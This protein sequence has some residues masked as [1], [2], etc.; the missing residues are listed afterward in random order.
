MPIATITPRAAKS[1]ING[2]QWVYDS[3]VER[4]DGPC[5]DG[6]LVSV[7]QSL[8]DAGRQR[9]LGQGFFNGHSKLRVRL[10]TRGPHETIDESFFRRRAREAC[11]YRRD[12]MPGAD[13]RR[14]VFGE[15]DGLPG[16]TVDQFHDVL[17]VQSLCL[18]MDRYKTAVLDELSRLLAADGI[19]V[20]GV[21]E[22][23]DV[24]I[25][26]LEGMEPFAGF[27]GEPFGT[28]VLIE[29]NGLRFQV[30]VANGQKTGYF[31]DQKLNR[32]AIRPLCRGKEVLDCFTHTGSFACNAAVTAKAVTALDISAGA[33]ELAAANARL[34]G[35]E[36]K[37]AFVQGDAFDLLPQWVREGRKF[38][39]VILDPPAL[40][41][42]RGTASRAERGYRELNI[43]GMKL[44]R[45]GGYLA[46]CSCSRFMTEENFAAVALQAAQTCGRT[47]R[48]VEKRAQA[49]DH[50]VLWGADET[51]Y[52]K[53]FVFQVMGRW[54]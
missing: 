44:L 39:V 23:S 19:A 40:T 26:E 11:Q 17:V 10:L 8:K 54:K 48:L 46:T 3:E 41:K 24:K 47:L 53:F 9:V 4:I 29:E 33:L 21:Y 27:L 51:Y 43:R 36:N 34:N 31:L 28:D 37:I 22:R 42:S 16:L 7:A 50:P 18:G 38:D 15:A 13:S 2:G 49:P 5:E 12:V 52:L 1:L 35:L 30:D 14:L 25:R 6:G 45:E 32:Q 20:R